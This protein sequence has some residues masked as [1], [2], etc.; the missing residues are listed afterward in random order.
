MKKWI[1]WMA[2]ML[3]GCLSALGAQTPPVEPP[4]DD[5]A[6][7]SPALRRV[8]SDKPFFG[9][10]S[11]LALNG[12]YINT[13]KEDYEQTGV[14]DVWS[15][16]LSLDEMHGMIAEVS[17]GG[18]DK[19][20]E[21]QLSYRQKMMT[22]DSEWQAIASANSA[23]SLSDR[24]SQVIKASYNVRDWWKVG[25]AAVVED[26]SGVDPTADIGTFGLNNRD[27]LGFQI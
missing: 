23:L 9:T 21:W 20:G 19:Q 6:D 5:S 26:R 7:Q 24:R 27:S 18:S 14:W 8:L 15:L 17:F 10:Q 25:L 1:T 13:P 2:M 3:I 22:M 12:T 16:P 11:L 4:A